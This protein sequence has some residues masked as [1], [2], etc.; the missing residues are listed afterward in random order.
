VRDDLYERADGEREL[1]LL[2]PADWG[3]RP[4]HRFVGSYRLKADMTW[5]PTEAIG[6]PDDT[7]HLIARLLEE[8]H[9]GDS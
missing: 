9:R 6:H 7:R 2:S 3:R 5:T 8:G 4:P 1:S